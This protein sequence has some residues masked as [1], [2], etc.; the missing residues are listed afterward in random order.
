MRTIQLTQGYHAQVDDADFEWLNKYSWSTFVSAHTNY[1][2]AKVNGKNT[3]M[4]RLI[5]GIENSPPSIQG[6]HVDGDGLNNQRNNLRI[7]TGQQNNYN[8]HRVVARTGVTG[9]YYRNDR[10]KP[11]YA[12]ITHN[13]VTRTIGYFD[14]LEE[15]A[16]AVAEARRALY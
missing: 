9:V 10:R 13:Y 3:F 15:A 8:R 12:Q 14:T 1:A 2:Q 11:Y 4:H 5:L 6:D 7:A 16:I